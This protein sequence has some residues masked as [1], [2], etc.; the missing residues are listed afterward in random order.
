[1]L[2]MC[3]SDLRQLLNLFVTW[4]WSTYFADFGSESSPYLRVK[5]KTALALLDK[6]KEAEKKK[7]FAIINQKDRDKKKLLERVYQELK[8][9]ASNTK[10]G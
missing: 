4:G 8:A 7:G 5:P 2:L 10:E 3:F 1:M 6:L 9:K